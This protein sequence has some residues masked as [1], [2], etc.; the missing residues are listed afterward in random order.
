ME[1]LF[2]VRDYCTHYLSGT[3]L[4]G[5]GRVGPS[6]SI[7]DFAWWGF[8][9]NNCHLSLPPHEKEG[10]FN[11]RN[12]RICYYYFFLWF[13]HMEVPRP[14]VA[15]ELQLPAYTMATVTLDLSHICDLRRSLQQCLFLNLWSKARDWSCVLIDTS[16]VLNKGNSESIL[17]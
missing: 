1:R 10:H 7:F 11:T 16:Q 9:R 4:S 15:L 12:V 6:I 5:A 2:Y 14:Q 17:L 13:W 8:E 3:W